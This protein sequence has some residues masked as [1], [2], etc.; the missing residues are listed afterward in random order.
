MT[1]TR[2]QSGSKNQASNLTI[3]DEY[4]DEIEEKAPIRVEFTNKE[5]S[6]KTIIVE[7]SDESFIPKAKKPLKRY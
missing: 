1:R 2:Q 4:H 7:M 3:V 6:Q 5:V